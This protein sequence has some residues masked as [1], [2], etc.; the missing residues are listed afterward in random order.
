MKKST[1]IVLFL[2]NTILTQTHYRLIIIENGTPHEA[3]KPQ[4]GQK[5]SKSYAAVLFKTDQYIKPKI[6]NTNAV[7]QVTDFNEWKIK[8]MQESIIKNFETGSNTDNC[9]FEY[10]I[11]E[12]K[13]KIKKFE[14]EQN[15]IKVE[16]SQELSNGYYNFVPGATFSHMR[17]DSREMVYENE[18]SSLNMAATE[19]SF[20]KNVLYI[21]DFVHE[22]KSDFLVL[23]F[24]A[25]KASSINVWNTDIKFDVVLTEGTEEEEAED[26]QNFDLPVSRYPTGQNKNK[27]Y[28]ETYHTPDESQMFRGIKTS[29]KIKSTAHNKPTQKDLCLVE[30]Y[31]DKKTLRLEIYCE[32]IVDGLKRYFT[33]FYMSE[34]LGEAVQRNGYNDVSDV[35]KYCFNFKLGNVHQTESKNYPFDRKFFASSVG[36]LTNYSSFVVEEPANTVIV[37][38]RAVSDRGGR[39]LI[40]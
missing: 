36:L 21:E 40:L 12:I 2:I 5:N 14:I 38:I 8:N 28:F 7:Y 4:E 9:N 29:L 33:K 18:G 20:R 10:P 26:L 19:F 16:R 39:R 22:S 32:L 23:K 31:T 37:T 6:K 3:K 15:P 35:Q 27:F 13:I 30:R 1:T 11:K 24:E 34:L 17:L 25:K